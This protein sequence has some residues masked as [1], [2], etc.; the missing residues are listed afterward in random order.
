MIPQ[1][2]TPH[3]NPC[4]LAKKWT[5]REDLAF[6]L[7]RMTSDLPFGLKIISGY[8]SPEKQDRLRAQ[9]RPT[10]N[11]DLSTHLSCPAGGADLWPDVAVTDVVKAT[12]GSAV[13]RA[14]LRWG[15]GSR[16]DPNT[17]IPSDWNHVDIGPRSSYD[18]AAR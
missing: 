2:I 3:T 12:F 8:R 17:G 1:A 9:G 14:G 6:K 10:A 7:V 18:R 4:D 15:G 11:N 16:K 5:L 13:V